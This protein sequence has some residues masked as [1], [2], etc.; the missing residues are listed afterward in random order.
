MP[1]MLC[2]FIILERVLNF[3]VGGVAPFHPSPLPPPHTVQLQHSC[4]RRVLVVSFFYESPHMTF[5]CGLTAM[6]NIFAGL[7]IAEVVLQDSDS[8][9]LMKA[10]HR[11]KDAKRYKICF[12]NPVVSRIFSDWRNSFN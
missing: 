3:C 9:K 6:A 11:Q 1:D 12:F 5:K 10:W 7:G 8:S 4:H 2:F